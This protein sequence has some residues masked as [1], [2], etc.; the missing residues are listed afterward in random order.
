MV[1]GV[2]KV[3]GLAGGVGRAAE[4]VFSVT[5]AALRQLVLAA[6]GSCVL[7]LADAALLLW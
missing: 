4:H 2:T 3:E 7:E 5:H 6:E 1:L